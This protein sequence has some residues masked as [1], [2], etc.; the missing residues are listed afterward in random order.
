M[1]NSIKFQ[2]KKKLD[3]LNKNIQS[4]NKL[5]LSVIQYDE[6]DIINCLDT[7]TR[8][9][10]TIGKEVLKVEKKIQRLLKI[11][12]AIMLNSGG[13]ANFLIL[14]LLTSV[15]AKKKD[16]LKPGDE[17]LTPAVT[18]S[19]TVSP[20]I[21]NN[22]V[23]VLVDVNLSTYDINVDLMEKA[24]TKK[25]KAIMLV[26][27][28]GQVCDMEKILKICK[29]YNLL[30][31]E[32]NCESIGAKYKNKFSGTFGKFS[33]ISMYQSHP[34]LLAG[35]STDRIRMPNTTHVRPLR[36][37]YEVITCY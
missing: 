27:P 22:L 6:T 25:T 35:P 15:Y 3:N 12:N 7:L 14:Y 20:I 30:L 4:N 37:R 29:K 24:I 36:I 31:I 19:T 34:A 8:G 9:W 18:W 1:Q 5:P 16:K 32:D 33:S 21:Q 2:I 11:K 26:H 10:P 23:P 17:V 13:S 28:L